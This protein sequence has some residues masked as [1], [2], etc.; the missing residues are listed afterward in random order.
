LPVTN[1]YKHGVVILPDGAPLV[2][3]IQGLDLII[4]KRTGNNWTEQFNSQVDY[5]S[6]F[7]I[8][9]NEEKIYFGYWL[10]AAQSYFVKKYENGLV[11]VYTYV[12]LGLNNP[13][14]GSIKLSTEY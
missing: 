4:H 10:G 13:N 3:I 2:G 7:Q 12:D 5:D 14:T 1:T 11:T 6:D 9:Q 8:V